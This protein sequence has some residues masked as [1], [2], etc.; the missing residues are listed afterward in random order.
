[1]KDLKGGRKVEARWHEEEW[2]IMERDFTRERLGSR[3]GERG[4]WGK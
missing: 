1:M 4:R 2:R 3:I